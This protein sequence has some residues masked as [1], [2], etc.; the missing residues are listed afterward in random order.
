MDTGWDR[1]DLKLPYP[2]H[3]HLVTPAVH[4]HP[5]TYIT[6]VCAANQQVWSV[7]QQSFLCSLSGHTNWVRTCQLSP[8]ARLA[9]SGGDDRTVRVWDVETRGAVSV[10][11]EQ[12]GGSVNVA[13]FHPE[14][15]WWRAQECVLSATHS[16]EGDLHC[17]CSCALPA[18]ICQGFL[19]LF[20]QM[21]WSSCYS[22]TP[23][24]GCIGRLAKDSFD[25]ALVHGTA[26]RSFPPCAGNCVAT[27]GTDGCIKLWDL[28]SGRIIQYYEAHEG[29]TTDVSFHPS[30]N[31]LLSSS[32]DGTL[33]ACASGWAALGLWAGIEQVSH[34]EQKQTSMSP[35]MLGLVGA[36]WLDRAA[37]LI[38]M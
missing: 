16:A 6:L 37:W 12:D 11:E 1:L 32:L 27:G 26:E 20:Y 4:L 18:L 35:E 38:K 29:A 14:G 31:F 17:V 33:K 30:G 2:E 21:L 28:R 10:F 22:T 24:H 5:L 19:L 23:K 13:R 34:V 25:D 36:N 3:V 8:D 7:P 15:E 9:V